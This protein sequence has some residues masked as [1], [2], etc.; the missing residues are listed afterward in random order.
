MAERCDLDLLDEAVGALFDSSADPDGVRRAQ[1][2]CDGLAD[3]LRPVLLEVA[4]RLGETSPYAHPLY[5]GHMLKPPHPAARLAYALALWPNPNNHAFD[6]GRASSQMEIEAVEQ[7]ARLFGWSG[8]LGHLC[9]G[10]TVA[11][12]EALWIARE[13]TRLY[14][15]PQAPAPAGGQTAGIAASAQAHYCHERAAALLGVPFHVV[16]VDTRGR[17]DP[18]AL[19]DL[20]QRHA[21]GTV[22]A[23]LGTP[24]AGAIDPLDQIADLCAAR[25]VRLHADASYGGYFTLAATLEP[26]ARRAFDALSRADS[27]VVDP[28]KHGLQPYGCGCLLLRDAASRPIYT[29][30]PGYAYLASDDPHLGAISLECSRPGAA[31]VA[32][33]ATLRVLPLQRGGGFARGLEASRQAALQLWQALRDD[34]RFRPRFVTLFPPELDV[35]VWAVRAPSASVASVRARDL[36]ATAQ[37]RGLHFSLA[38]LPRAMI[39]P[40]HVVAHWDA[41]DLVVLRACLMKPEHLEWMA[42]ILDGLDAAADVKETP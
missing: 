5:L 32:L 36:H 13:S 7:I 16:P 28:H 35:V 11:N 40:L 24:A 10:G 34:A 37:A 29:H 18:A 42:R 26:G 4:Q 20:L 6:G 27:I 38:R 21:I 19:T 17:M 3:A 22:V 1:R 25:G 23:T 12:L 39:E 41:D 31:A 2:L 33:W 8:A 14:R 30:A 15:P 9:S